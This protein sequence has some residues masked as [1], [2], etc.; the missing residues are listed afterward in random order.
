MRNRNFDM[1]K[2]A[3]K[4]KNNLNICKTLNFIE[5]KIWKILPKLILNEISRVFIKLFPILDLY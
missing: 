3:R 2:N 5:T 4:K 1:M